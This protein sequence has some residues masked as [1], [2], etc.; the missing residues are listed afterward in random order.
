VD[1]FPDAIGAG[2][3]GHD[4]ERHELSKSDG[5]SGRRAGLRT[6]VCHVTHDT[7]HLVKRVVD[8]VLHCHESRG[9]RGVGLE[10]RGDVA[11]GIRFGLDLFLGNRLNLLF[12]LLL[13]LLL[14]DDL[15]GVFVVVDDLLD[16][17]GENRELVVL[18]RSYESRARLSAGLAGVVEG[19]FI[20]GVADGADPKAVGGGLAFLG[21]FLEALGAGGAGGTG[22]AGHGSGI[23]EI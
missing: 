11:L 20:V 17:L 12:D 9:E 22:G 2:S 6:W 18:G 5:R 7:L 14:R 16:A 1:A 23:M 3:L 21:G 8:V 10:E 19:A 4:L 15:G 13:D